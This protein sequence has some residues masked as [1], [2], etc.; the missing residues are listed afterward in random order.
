MKMIYGIIGFLIIGGL[1]F[2]ITSCNKK[3]NKKIIQFEIQKNQ[4]SWKRK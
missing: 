3:G 2:F 4:T 1:I